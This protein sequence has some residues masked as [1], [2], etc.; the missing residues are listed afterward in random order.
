M[1]TRPSKTYSCFCRHEWQFNCDKLAQLPIVQQL[2]SHEQHA[3]LH[4]LLQ[5]VAHEMFEGY[6]TFSERPEAASFMEKHS[7]S[8]DACVRKMRLLSLVS[9]G[10]SSKELTYATIAAAL[11]VSIDQVEL[12]VMEAITSGLIAAKIDQVRELVIVT[13]CLEREFGMRQW[14]SVK[15]SLGEWGKSVES[16][17]QVVLE[18][19]PSATP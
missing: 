14:D 17:L 1:P 19:R 16:L 9:L 12:W 10:Q 7:L 6:I 18:S 5:V 3:I 11:R 15:A 13:W 2:S 4:E 8:H